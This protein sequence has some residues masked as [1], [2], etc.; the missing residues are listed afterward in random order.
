MSLP[1]KYPDDPPSIQLEGFPDHIPKESIQEIS[2]KLDEQ[3]RS[4]PGYQVRSI[5]F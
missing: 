2:D 5:G 4:M 1:E 3:S